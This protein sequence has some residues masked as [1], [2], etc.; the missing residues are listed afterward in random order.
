V[1][2]TAFVTGG[3][4][5]LGRHVVE[6][7]TAGGWS[8]VALH[9]ATSDVS[10]L[11]TYPGV[12]LAE[13]T[14]TDA[15]SLARAMPEGCDAVFH[16]AANTNFW[17]GGN[18]QQTLDNVDGTRNVVETAIAK[19]AKKLVHTSSESTWGEVGESPFDE[20]TPQRG[21]ESWINY[22]RTKYLAEVEVLKGA[23]RGLPA[24][25]LCPGHIVGRYDTHNWATLIKLTAT[26]K[27]PG[28]PPGQGTW[29]GASQVARAHVT[30]VEKGRDGE[31]YL[32]GGVHA[33][34]LETIQVIARLA[35]KSEPKKVTPGWVLRAI[36]RVSQWNSYF[37]KKAPTITPELTAGIT[38]LPHLFKSDKAIRE[39]DYRAVP[40]EEMLRDAYEWL[41]S[42]KLLPAE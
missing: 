20:T 2:R 1:P 27:L 23:E 22:E 12:R 17:S 38:R 39:L 15:E 4:G 29:A 41:K 16:V 8:I 5:F 3:T 35:G 13:G 18:A 25:I 40:L 10:G 28:V 24:C 7:L 14:I 32:L 31:R 37:T 36:A 30:A 9:R 33:S 34:Y 6:Q 42:E 26:E 21:G 11:K 19:R